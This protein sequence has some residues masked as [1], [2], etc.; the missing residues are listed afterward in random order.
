MSHE[1][2]QCKHGIVESRCRCIHGS[3]NITIVPCMT[4][5]HGVLLHEQCKEGQTN[6]DLWR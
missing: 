2:R 6:A 1:V 4:N 3:Q 5:H